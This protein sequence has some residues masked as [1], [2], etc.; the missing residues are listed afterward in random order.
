MDGKT[1]IEL[2]QETAKRF[3]EFCMMDSITNGKP[4]KYTKSQKYPD[5]RVTI[6][7]VIQKDLT[8]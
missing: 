5:G 4:F 7:I 8:L 1:T 3:I 6:H 2:D